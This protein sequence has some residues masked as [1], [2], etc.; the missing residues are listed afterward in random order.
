M[1]LTPHAKLARGSGSAAQGAALTHANAGNATTYYQPR[2]GLS[3][4]PRLRDDFTRWQTSGVGGVD[5]GKELICGPAVHVPSRVARGVYTQNTWRRDAEW[6]EYVFP[7]S[8]R[9]LVVS[10]VPQTYQLGN[11]LVPARPFP[12]ENY[13]LGYVPNTETAMIG[14]TSTSHPLGS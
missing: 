9:D 1:P 14:G 3:Y 7:P 8:R 10:Q 2:S 13:F 11:V 6:Q 12:P 5:D 4:Q